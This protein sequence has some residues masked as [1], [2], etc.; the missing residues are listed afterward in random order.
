MAMKAADLEAEL[1]DSI[2]ARVRERLQGDQVQPCEAFVR[3]Y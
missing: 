2:C 1:I 3:Q